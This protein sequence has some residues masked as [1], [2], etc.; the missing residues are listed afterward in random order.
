MKGNLEH[1]LEVLFLEIFKAKLDFLTWLPS[2]CD[3]LSAPLR[4]LDY[5]LVA[6]TTYYKLKGNLESIM[7]SIC[8][9][10]SF[11]PNFGFC[12]P[13]SLPL[14]W[15]SPDVS[16]E[17]WGNLCPIIGYLKYTMAC[18][19]LQILDTIF[20]RDHNIELVPITIGIN[21]R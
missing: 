1:L 5:R 16:S 18:S 8:F 14:R 15:G 2:L 20:W 19:S 17:W 21:R 7:E 13:L 6:K 11:E 12:D 3:P 4:F 10:E 9:F